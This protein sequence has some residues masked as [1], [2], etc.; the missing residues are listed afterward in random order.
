MVHNSHAMKRVRRL[1]SKFISKDLKNKIVLIAGPRQT[2][3]TTLARSVSPTYDYLNFDDSD[4]RTKLYNKEWRRDVPLVIFDEI[5]KM[6]DWKRWLKGIYDV[7]GTSPKLLVTGSARLDMLRRVG[8]SLAGRYFKYRL[9][10]LDIKE[11]LFDDPKKDPDAIL[12]RLMKTGGFP[13]PYLKGSLAFYKKWRKSHLDIILHQDLVQLE[14][15]RHIS[16]I[17]TLVE[18]LRSRVGSPVSYQS[19]AED[20]QYSSHTIKNWIEI[21][22]NLQI[23]FKVTPYH[24][25]IARSLLKTPKFYFFD[26]AAVKS[27]PGAQFENLVALSLLKECHYLEDTRG[28]DVGLYYLRTKE[29]HEVDFLTD[30]EG[31]QTLVE[32]KLSDGDLAKSLVYFRKLFPSAR[33]YQV[34]KSLDREYSTQDKIFVKKAARWLAEFELA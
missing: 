17:E 8:D 34:V 12:D 10:P 2:G 7:E 26:V 20:L 24:K 4:H 22:E 25:D 5:H 6:K 14:E 31:R 3:K 11:I 19:L 33:A 16:A 27:G 18:M 1:I 30:I 21:L 28:K 15:V 9:Y 29:G 23:I 32:A 13:E